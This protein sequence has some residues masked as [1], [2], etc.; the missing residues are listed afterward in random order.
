MLLQGY[1]RNLRLCRNDSMETVLKIMTPPTV[2]LPDGI[3][4]N[5]KIASRIP[6]KGSRHII[7]PMVFADNIFKLFTKRPKDK[8]VQKIPRMGTKK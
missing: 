1:A 2:V 4:F 3:S 6:Y 8:A 7:N 5:I